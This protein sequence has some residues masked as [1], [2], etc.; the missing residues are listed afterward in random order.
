MVY[1]RNVGM[2]WDDLI[3]LQI[4]LS[5]GNTYTVIDIV[6]KD[7]V[8]FLE[9]EDYFGDTFFLSEDDC[10]CGSLDDYFDDNKELPVCFIDAI[11]EDYYAS[12][13]FLYDLKRDKELMGW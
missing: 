13:D 2:Y 1:S 8:L 9:L 5:D 11:V 6:K 10:F 7:D 3:D 4:E 12:E